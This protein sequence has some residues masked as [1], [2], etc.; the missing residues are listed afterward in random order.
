[1]RKDLPVVILCGGMGS[2]LSEETT[3]RP[4]PMVEIGGMPILWHIMKGYSHYGYKNFILALGYKADYIK[5]Y[6]YNF[7]ISSCDFTLSMDP[8]S[9]VLFHNQGDEKDWKIT[10][11]DT[12]VE[13]LKGARI[14]RIEQYIK[15][16]TFFLTYGD[17][18][19]NV[20]I[21]DLYAFHQRHGKIGTLTAVRPPSRFGMIDLDGDV[22]HTFEEKPQLA[23]GYINGGFFVL[24]RRIFDYLR[25]DADC[26][27][28]F[29]PMQQLA[30][31][32]ELRAYKHNDFWQCMDTIR[33][34]NYLE[35]LWNIGEARWK[36]W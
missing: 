29:G 9:D 25:T 24:N 30:L 28:E 26:D 3:E 22:V 21:D 8:N 31:D 6:F 10:F 12:G 23:E 13:T 1:M 32:G 36:T 33:E 16:D 4:K 15:E 11:V 17:G 5:N 2:R 19:S 35:K 27:F 14:K 18:V 7:R 34:K 20:N